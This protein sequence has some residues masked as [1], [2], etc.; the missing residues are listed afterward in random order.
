MVLYRKMKIYYY[1]YET[2]WRLPLRLNLSR[3]VVNTVNLADISSFINRK[4]IPDFYS[5]QSF[6]VDITEPILL[7]FS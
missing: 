5:R 2:S 6:V 1:F 7:R 4:L 3:S